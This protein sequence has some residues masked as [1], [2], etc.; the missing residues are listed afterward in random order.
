MEVSAVEMTAATEGES[1]APSPT[2]H[3][4]PTHTTA[5]STHTVTAAHTTAVSTTHTATTHT[6]TASHTTTMSTTAAATVSTTAAALR[7]CDTWGKGD[8][9]TDCGG[10]GN[11][12]E[13]LAKHGL[14]SY[15]ERPR[16]DDSSARR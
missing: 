10:D 8:R 14:V 13:S 4:M 12:D 1:T 2:T 11:G 6:V 7:R 9:C 15:L 3:R 5:V 16:T